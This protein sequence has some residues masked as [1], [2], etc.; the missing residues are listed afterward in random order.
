M[1]AEGDRAPVRA[2]EGIGAMDAHIRPYTPADEEPVVA[3]SLRAWE[4]IFASLKQI[5][6]D[7]LFG[8]LRGDWR[9][10]QEQAV[11]DVLADPAEHIWVADSNGLVGWVAATLHADSGI[12]EIYMIA[13][14]PNAQNQG[15][16]KGLTDVATGWLRESGMRVAMVETGGDQGHAPARRVYENAGYTALPAVR[17][18]KAL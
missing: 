16:G 5:V 17:Y 1:S 15:V 11:H 4:P 7:E 8:I 6:G 14:D 13:V 9:V 10:S 12:G 18:F 2:D 3:L